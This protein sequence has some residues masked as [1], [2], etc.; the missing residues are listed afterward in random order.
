MALNSR[1]RRARKYNLAVR[2]LA[3]A[4]NPQQVASEGRVRSVWGKTLPPRANIREQ[5][6]EGEGSRGKSVN[7][8]LVRPK[9]H[10]FTA[11]G[12][13][14]IKTVDSP[15]HSG[16]DRVELLPRERVKAAKIAQHLQVRKREEKWGVKIDS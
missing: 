2:A 7:G 3:K 16:M 4:R 9:G 14:R 8:K 5:A 13:A 1:Q 12:Q 10:Q 15:S 6:W 11:D